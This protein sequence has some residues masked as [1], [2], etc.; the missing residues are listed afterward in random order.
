MG[1]SEIPKIEEAIK[2]HNKS[3]EVLE[4]ELRLDT[5]SKVA[6]LFMSSFENK[7]KLI[8]DKIVF[9]S[10]SILIFLYFFIKANNIIFRKHNLF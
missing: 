1:P 10:N 4:R 3:I 7:L 9:K 2:F 6:C 5:A 8:R